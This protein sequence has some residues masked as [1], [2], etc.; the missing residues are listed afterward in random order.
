MS[1]DDDLRV[2]MRKLAPAQQEA[3]RMRVMGA[4][5]DG[6]SPT[7]A[8]RVFGVSPDS[9]RNWR[10]RQET[11]R[12]QGLRSGRPGRKPG[13]HTKLTPAQE[14]A[15]AQALLVYEPHQ[16]GL[17]G[18]LWTAVKVAALVQQLF[19]TTFTDRGIRKILRRLGLTFQRPDRRACQADPGAQQEWV[20]Q[21]W[22]DL[23]ERARVQ[24]ERVMFADQVGVRSDH[25]SGRTWGLKGHTPATTRSGDRFGVNAMS[26]IS[27]T[28]KLYFTV[29]EGSFT[30]RVFIGFLDRLIKHFSA[31]VHLVV[32]QHSVHRSKAVRAWVHDHA[33]RIELHFLPPYSP[34]LN[35]DELVN[36]D[37]KR[38]LTDEV[39][40]DRQRMRSQ[41]RSFF[42]SVQR[43]AG[44]VRS[45]FQAPHTSY[46]TRTI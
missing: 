43:L 2:D 23:R 11:D 28:G 20:E 18:T 3:L 17:G 37:L 5:N 1:D 35:P 12:V 9:I 13:E 25:L 4:I 24:G 27:P 41:V 33:E 7:E 39:I 44:H 6:M 30:A 32:D 34:H 14:Q 10:R 22:P 29:F 21:T 45:Y 8:V 46:I 15:L 38:H 31:K 16:L 36:A 19:G 40:T 26:A 42:R